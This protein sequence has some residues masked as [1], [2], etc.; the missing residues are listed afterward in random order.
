M[1]RINNP[2]I[3]RKL[4]YYFV[5]DTEFDSKIQACLHAVE[6]KK[7][8]I[9]VFNN[10][11]F[12]KHD[13]KIE[14]EQSLDQLY[15]RRARQLR[16]S[17]DYIVLSYSGGADSHNI[18]MS[19]YRQ[20]LHIDEIITNTMTKASA[21]AIVVDPNNVDAH[22][23]PEAEHQLHT[24][25]RL[26]EISS[27]MPKTKITITDCSDAL[28][29]ELETAGDASWVLTKREGLNPAGMTR[30]NFLHFNEV[31]RQFDKDRKIAVVVGIEKPR[32]Q[33]FRGDFIMSFSDRTA[34][35]I[36][37]SEHL[38]EYPNS[39]VEFFY[40]TPDLVELLIKQGHV[41]KRWLEAFPENQAIWQSHAVTQEMYRLVHDKLLRNL[42][43]TT[44]NPNWYQAK[45]AIYDWHSEFDQ[46]FVDL[47]KDTRAG[48][49][50]IE[51]IDFVKN[52]LKPFLKRP[53]YGFVDGLQVVSHTY[54][55]GPMKNLQ[56]DALWIR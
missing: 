7:P 56:A 33:I 32:T 9:W 24:I 5:G 25:H 53:E 1:T 21:K 4:G 45:K 8:V 12:G 23:A 28:F 42:L 13:W 35:M 49:V 39:T 20:G 16:E 22:N 2:Y 14:P 37:V 10:D 52:K 50:W 26:K 6:V 41:I 47:Y 27:W 48:Q 31:R 55:L 36:T 38:K 18:L 46:W 43:Y 15:D 54:N 11:E 30:F 17:Y 3:N 40:W 44:W 19:F 29:D 34:N 51:G